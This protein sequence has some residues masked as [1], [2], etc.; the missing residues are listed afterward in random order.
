MATLH[1]GVGTGSWT[2]WE[3]G[4]MILPEAEAMDGTKSHFGEK[5]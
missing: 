2:L 1:A 3:Q 5:D 4:K